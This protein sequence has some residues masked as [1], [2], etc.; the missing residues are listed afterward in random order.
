[1]QSQA[2]YRK[3]DSGRTVNSGILSCTLRLL[4]AVC[5]SSAIVVQAEPVTDP[6]ALMQKV[7][8]RDV[9]TAN[10]VTSGYVVNNS[11]RWFSRVELIV[12]YHQLAGET[13]RRLEPGQGLDAHADIVIDQAVAPYSKVRFSYQP[14]DFNPSDRPDVVTTVSVVSVQPYAAT[15]QNEAEAVR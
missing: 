7:Y 11:N 4:A 2:S 1:M 12:R 14:R 6:Q 3:P 5:V 15:S 10:G 13:P 8:L 9:R